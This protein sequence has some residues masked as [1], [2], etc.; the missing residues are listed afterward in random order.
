MKD[1]FTDA[2]L[3]LAEQSAYA[4]HSCET[5]YG[6]PTFMHLDRMPNLP[7]AD[8]TG[9]RDA[10]CIFNCEPMPFGD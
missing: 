10:S 8:D 6:H 1:R 5:T 4:C 9:W 2:S 3:E 7:A